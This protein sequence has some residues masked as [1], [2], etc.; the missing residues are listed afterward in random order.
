MAQS[1]Y[2]GKKRSR[3]EWEE[4]LDSSQ[5]Q[6]WAQDSH[7]QALSE[8]SLESTT[9]MFSGKKRKRNSKLSEHRQRYL[10]SNVGSHLNFDHAYTIEK[11]KNKVKQYWTEEEV[12]IL[13]L[14]FIWLIS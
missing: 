10:K 13:T 11:Q 12:G 2:C 14:I 4:A 9:C 8:S 6:L 5:I 7:S 1:K 3:I